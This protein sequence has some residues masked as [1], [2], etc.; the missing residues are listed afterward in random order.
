MDL[1]EFIPVAEESGQIQAIGLWVV[2]QVLAQIQSWR[3]MELTVLRISVNVSAY[4]L[5]DPAFPRTVLER[6]GAHGLRNSQMLC[7]GPG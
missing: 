7:T 2:E 4:Q 3:A 6:L 5:A 1:A